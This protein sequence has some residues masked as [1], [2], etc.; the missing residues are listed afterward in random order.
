MNRKL[1]I[2]TQLFCMVYWD[3][4]KCEQYKIIKNQN[5]YMC[6]YFHQLELIYNEILKIKLPRESIL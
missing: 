5:Q 1:I 6:M 3:D 4:D 2:M